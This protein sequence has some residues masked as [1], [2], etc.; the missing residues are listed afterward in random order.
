[1]SDPTSASSSPPASERRGVESHPRLRIL[2]VDD[3]EDS[4]EM[5]GELLEQQG[6]ETRIAY[7]AVSALEVARAFVPQVALLDLGMPVVDGTHLAKQ[8]L[9][10]PGLSNLRLVAV[11]GYGRTEDRDK[12]LRAGFAAPLLKPVEADVLLAAVWDG[13]I[14]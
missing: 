9:A 13:I 14:A 3:Y 4:A 5:M 2:I 10:L 1:M 8:L 7:S 6:H 11:T 12:T